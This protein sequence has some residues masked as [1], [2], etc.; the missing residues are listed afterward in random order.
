LAQL[1]VALLMLPWL[2]LALS[3]MRSWSVVE[4]PA[5]LAFVLQLNAVLLT[6]GIST[7][8]GQ[9]TLPALAVTLGAVIGL[10]LVLRRRPTAWTGVALL[11]LGTL[12]PSIIV[13]LLTQ[14]RGFFYTPQVEARYLLPYAPAFYA[15]L[16]WALVGWL[17]TRGAGRWIGVLFWGIVIAGSAWTLPQHYSPRYFQDTYSS[18]VRILWAYGRPDD[19]V[20]LVSADRYPL[21]HTYY[22]RPWAPETR[23]PVYGLP[24]GPPSVTPDYLDTALGEIT[25]EHQRIWLVQVERALQDPEGLTEAWLAERYVRPLSYDFAHNNLSLFAPTAS[26]PTIPPDRVAPQ[27]P[28]S[29]TLAPGVSLV[30]YDLPTDEFRAGDTIRLGLY[31]RATQPA[32]LTMALRGADG[33][34]VAQQELT[35]EAREGAVRRQVSFEVV[36]YTPSQTYH[37]SVSTVDDT[38]TYPLGDLRV[39]H[40]HRAPRIDRIPHPLETQLG[41]DIH[42]LGYRLEGVKRGTPPQAQ[43]GDSLNLTLYWR[44]DV[45]LSENYHVFTH[46]IGTAHN[47]ATGGP[48]WGQDDQIPLEGEYPTYRWLVG[49]PLADHYAVEIDPQAPPGD[50]QL[51]VGMYLPETGA[52]LP[53]TGENA[54]PDARYVL[55]TRV[56]IAP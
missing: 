21:F 12:L 39:T 7:Y 48:L 9:Y 11:A 35:V 53:V 14:P 45:P 10:I 56:R 42:L 33:R 52:R 4:E 41:D 28:E 6:L 36:P 54:V 32:T 47:P 40:T 34:S 24:Q 43:P 26:R 25:D 44:T 29:L 20:V 46:L 18:L 30:G 37:F 38:A 55:L 16:A 31:L 3:R 51:A 13:W 5:S 19:A 17:R 2:G 8:V 1:G 15:L 49:I 50:Y 23:P 27:Y 22:D